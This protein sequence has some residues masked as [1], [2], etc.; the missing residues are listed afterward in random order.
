[1]HTNQA[2]RGVTRALT[3]LL[4][5]TSLA[6]CA[7]EAPVAP[8]ARIPEGGVNSLLQRVDLLPTGQQFLKKPAFI[9]GSPNG[10]LSYVQ[11]YDKDG[12][13]L[14]RFKAFPNEWDIGGAEVALGDINAALRALGRFQYPK[15]KHFQLHLRC[16]PT[17]APMERD[18]TFR[19]MLVFPRP[20]P[21]QHC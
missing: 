13:Q 3:A 2:A 12:A 5:A 11:V 21:G 20:A 18:S 4:A 16:S 15:D 17:F 14:I 1:M 9:T 6:A 19:A 8:R 7:D 10:K